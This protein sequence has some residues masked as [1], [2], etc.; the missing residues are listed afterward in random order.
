MSRRLLSLVTSR[1]KA[2]AWWESRSCAQQARTGP[3]CQACGRERAPR[4]A[5]AWPGTQRIGGRQVAAP[6]C[7][8]CL[9][10]HSARQNGFRKWKGCRR[11]G[12]LYAPSHAHPRS[13]AAHTRA[14][15]RGAA[16]RDQGRRQLHMLGKSALRSPQR[17]RPCKPA[18][19]DEGR[20]PSRQPRRELPGVHWSSPRPSSACGAR[21]A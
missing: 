14:R 10:W 11:P 13:V 18:H 17:T 9:Q 3:S 7:R 15:L 19:V 6:T 20:T 4:E 5:A 1:R 2:A 21:L 16:Q 12:R 8:S